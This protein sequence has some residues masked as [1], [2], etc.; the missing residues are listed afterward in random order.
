MKRNLA[1]AAIAVALVATS[2]YAQDRAPRAGAAGPTDISGVF[3]A[4]S[5]IDYPPMAQWGEASTGTSVREG[6]EMRVAG[7]PQPS[8]VD[9]PPI[10]AGASTGSGAPGRLECPPPS[11]QDFPSTEAAQPPRR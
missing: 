5:F 10:Q 11:F 4:P 6:R 9:C 1:V 8:F 7:V 2:A 3:P